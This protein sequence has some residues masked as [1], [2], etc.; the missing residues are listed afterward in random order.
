IAWKLES[1]DIAF[2]FEFIRR[3]SFRDINFGE[4]GRNGESFRVADRDSVRPGFKL[5]R[6]CGM[7]QK[8]P[9]RRPPGAKAPPA[10][11]HAR[12]CVAFGGD[13]PD[14]IIDCLYLYREFA[15]EALRILVPYT[16]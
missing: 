9:R 10:Q 6:H 13:D 8:P 7:V 2:G 14:N 5:C 12:D 11:S 4:M 1:D 3:A 15:S 16:R